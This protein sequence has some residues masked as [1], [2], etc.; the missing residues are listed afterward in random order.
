M[1]DFSD[2]SFHVGSMVGLRAFK[3]DALGRLVGPSQGG[4]FKPGEN[5]AV[6]KKS[7]G[8]YGVATMGGQTYYYSPG[9]WAYAVDPAT[10]SFA[11]PS[12]SQVTAA[13]E[14]GLAEKAVEP[15]DPPKV[16]PKH[17]VAGAGC[18][19]GFY[20]YFD[21][22]NDYMVTGR[23][24]AVVEGYGTYML[25]TRGFRSSKARLLG[26]IVPKFGRYEG[27]SFSTASADVMSPAVLARVVHN[28]PDVPFYA[29]Q[30][31]AI[32]AHPLHEPDLPTPEMFDDFWTRSA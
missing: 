16:K 12:V 13:A 31:E 23:I 28:Y 24:A 29:S 32:E 1:S 7:D 25:G 5:E 4:I 26:L 8:S 21:G 22:L 10:N 11:V 9:T 19:C 17:V 6:C 3:V 14:L 30:D 15:N 2:R 20:A 27:A 18:L